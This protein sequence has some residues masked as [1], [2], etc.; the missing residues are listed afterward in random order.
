MH[1]T[2]PKHP[3][4]DSLKCGKLLEIELPLIEEGLLKVLQ[5]T[6][7]ARLLYEA[8]LHPILSG[9]K[10]VR[11]LLTLVSCESVG[12]DFRKALP[13]AIAIE[14]IH[15]ASLIH[16][17]LIDQ[18]LER[19]GSPTVHVKYGV[20]LATLAGDLLISKAMHILSSS[21]GKIREIVSQACVQMCEG[22]CMDMIFKK[23]PEAVTEENYLEMAKKKTGALVRAAAM[24]GAIIGGGSNRQVEALSKYGEFVGLSLQLRDDVQEILIAV[25]G[26]G[27]ATTNRLLGEGSNLVLIHSFNSSDR[28]SR[29]SLRNLVASN[30]GYHRTRDAIRLLRNSTSIHH[31][32]N[33]SKKFKEKAKKAVS[34][35][36]FCNEGILEDLAEMV[37]QY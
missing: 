9:G 13:E 12:G 1:S 3:L 6:S 34:G 32:Q 14:L 20:D 8:S 23:H 10:R 15:T 18:D 11:P 4:F 37:S 2:K 36:N 22:E 5:S 21:P 17:D 33:L 19:R 16:D 25:A 26:C 28:P 27:A 35:M 30:A 31:V 29:D 7:K 24:C